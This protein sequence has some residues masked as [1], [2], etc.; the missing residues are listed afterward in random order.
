MYKAFKYF[1]NI[2]MFIEKVKI[3][4]LMNA[5]KEDFKENFVYNIRKWSW[6]FM[7]HNFKETLLNSK[8]PLV[9]QYPSFDFF[10]FN[11]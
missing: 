4:Y 9:I 7:Q 5:H 2:F 3:S 6:K 11:S 1:K 8:L 10:L